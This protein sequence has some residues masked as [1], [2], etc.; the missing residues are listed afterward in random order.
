M[1]NLTRRLL[2]ALIVISMPAMASAE[3]G[4]VKMLN[5]GEKVSMVFEP[6]FL[7]LQPADSVKYIAANKSHNAATIDGMLPDG[8]PG[9]KGKIN[10]EIVVTFDRPGFYGIKCSPHYGMGMVMLI[11]VGDVEL[12]QNYRAI[13]VPAR[14][15][16]RFEALFAQAEAELA[17]K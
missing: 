16:P 10:E 11:K 7:A 9:F 12:P 4:E 3:T 13:E 1:I 14:A 15:M 5:R 17:G 8:H 2:F 6:D